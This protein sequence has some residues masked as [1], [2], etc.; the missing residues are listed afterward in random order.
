M[1]EKKEDNEHHLLEQLKSGDQRALSEL[2]HRYSNRLTYYVQRTS[3]SP[4]LAEDVV[5]DTFIK[6]WQSREQLDPSKPFES[7]LFV[8]AK[9]TLLNL[10]KRARHETSI[11]AE[12]KKY[13]IIEDESTEKFLAYQESNRLINAAIET[14]SGQV[15]KTFIYCRVQDM[16]YKQAAEALNITE[17]TVNKHMSKALQTIRE[18]VRAHHSST[19]LFFFIFYWMFCRSQLY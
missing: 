3:K 7:Y 2:Y 19:I 10:L 1:R 5:H 4:F 16:S 8:I 13:A 17:S 18:Y 9:R 12:I 15:K 6:I 14:L 11:L